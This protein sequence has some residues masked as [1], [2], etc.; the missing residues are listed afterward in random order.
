VRG[1]EELDEAAD[2]TGLDDFLDGRIAFFR[3]KLSEFGRGLDLRF[4]LVGEDAFDHL[5][6]FGAQLYV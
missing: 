2:D 1:A 6:Q 3:Q 4:D 5:W